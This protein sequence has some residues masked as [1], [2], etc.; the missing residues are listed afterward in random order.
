MSF[1]EDIT[2]SVAAR[3]DL[4]RIKMVDH[5]TTGLHTLWRGPRGW[6]SLDGWGTIHTSVTS[7]RV[8][9]LCSVRFRGQTAA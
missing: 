6:Y 1:L 4:F 2:Q 5:P 7:Q 8:K 3:Y 9:C